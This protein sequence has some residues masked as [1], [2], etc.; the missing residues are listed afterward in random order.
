MEHNYNDDYFYDPMPED[1][2]PQ[3]KPLKKKVGKWLRGDVKEYL[4][5]WN[6]R[7]S[8]FVLDYDY[9]IDFHNWLRDTPTPYLMLKLGEGYE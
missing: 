8:N 3:R 1:M 5:S 7:A 2:P 4:D 9:Q 6:L